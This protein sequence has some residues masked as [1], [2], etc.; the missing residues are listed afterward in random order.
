MRA[1][2]KTGWTLDEL[3]PRIVPAVWIVIPP[4]VG[5]P[6]VEQRVPDAAIKGLVNAAL[7]ANEAQGD[8]CWIV[9]FQGQDPT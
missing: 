5:A 9:S 7:R 2:R 8:S 3:E 4:G 6:V 1:R